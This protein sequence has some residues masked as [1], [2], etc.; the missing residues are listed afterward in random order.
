[1]V[2]VALKGIDQRPLVRITN[3]CQWEGVK[4][5][6]VCQGP[7]PCETLYIAIKNRLSCEMQKALVLLSQGTVV[8][9]A[10]LNRV[11]LQ[12]HRKR[13]RYSSDLQ[14]TASDLAL[15]AETLARASV[16]TNVRVALDW[17]L[18]KILSISLGT[19]LLFRS[20]FTVSAKF[21]P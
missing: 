21:V 13:N 17:T 7:T 18:T 10:V 5:N 16:S 14:S 20:P 6:P 12:R 15:V 3:K 9:I 11:S 2:T 19:C 8:A 1:M 4:G